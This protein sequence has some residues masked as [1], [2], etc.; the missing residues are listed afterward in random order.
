MTISLKDLSVEDR[1]VAEQAIEMM[2]KKLQWPIF[3]D[4]M[5][6]LVEVHA[7]GISTAGN[8][9]MRVFQVAGETKSGE[10][11]GWKM[12]VLSRVDFI[13]LSEAPRPGYKKGD[14]G[15]GTIFKEL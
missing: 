7:V 9:C 3:Y 6:R 12:M 13:S 4:G 2:D 10:E 1:I 8:P 5:L 15:M 14:K 11:L